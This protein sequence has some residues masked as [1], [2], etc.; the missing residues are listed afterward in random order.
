MEQTGRARR[1][2]ISMGSLCGR[3][4]RDRSAN[5]AIVVVHPM[6]FTFNTLAS[7][8]GS[9]DAWRKDTFQEN[10]QHVETTYARHICYIVSGE[11]IIRRTGPGN[12]LTT[13]ERE[14]SRPACRAQVLYVPCCQVPSVTRT[15]AA[16][17]GTYVLP[18]RAPGVCTRGERC[19]SIT[20]RRLG[21]PLVASLCASR[22][23]ACIGVHR[24]EL[25]V[26]GTTLD[27]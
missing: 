20:E 25:A 4:S 16:F 23:C 12:I 7:L 2:S 19:A 21:L 15:P 24:T 17:W 18:V 5:Q 11:R 10:V 14:S 1:P 27:L 26:G 8:L 9:E 3:D 22:S 13:S 6:P